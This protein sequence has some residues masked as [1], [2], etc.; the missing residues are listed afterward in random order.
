MSAL[1]LAWRYLQ[2]RLPLNLLTALT[3][4][5]GVT[6]IIAASAVSN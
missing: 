6:L 2:A 3:V 1:M 4:A 5:F